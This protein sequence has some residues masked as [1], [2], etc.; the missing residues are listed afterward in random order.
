V[1]TRPGAG[2]FRAAPPRDRAGRRGH[3]L[4]GGRAQRGRRRR[5][6]TAHGGRVRG[7]RHARRPAAGRD[8]VQRRLSAPV[9]PARARDGRRAVPG[10]PPPRRLGP[11]ADGGPAG[12]ARV[13]RAGHRRCRD[14]RRRPDQ[15]GRPVRAHHRAARPRPARRTRPRRIPHLSRHAG[16]RR[17]AGLSARAGAGGRGRRE[18]GPAR[19]RVPRDRRPRLRLPAA[20]PEPDRRGARP[21]AP[22]EVLRIARDAGAFVIE[23]DFVRR[24]VH[25]DA[26]RCRVRSPPTTPTESS[27]TSARS[28]RRPRRA[29]G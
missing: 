25:E 7:P 8:R 23:D 29:S 27:C 11:A 15:R 16:D 18:T 22:P 5:L 19:R 13:V 21:R 9:A 24:L 6:R 28:P 20:L 1:V 3:L 4:A 2:A 14:G 10:R 17:A 12:A 26:G